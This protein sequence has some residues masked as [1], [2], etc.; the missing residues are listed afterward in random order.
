MCACLGVRVCACI[1]LYNIKKVKR[2]YS[3]HE[4]GTKSNLEIKSN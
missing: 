2:E 4:T 1:Y 3:N